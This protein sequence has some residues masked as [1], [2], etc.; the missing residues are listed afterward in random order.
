MLFD[1]S[2]A[3]A[4]LEGQLPPAAPLPAVLQTLGCRWWPFAYLQWCQAHLGDRFTVYPIDMPPLVFLADPEDIHTVLTASPSVLH[5]GEGAAVIAPLIGKSSFML[6]EED[7]HMYGR[8]ATIPAF[9]RAVVHE[10]RALVDGII[11]REVAS[12]PVD[13]PMELHPRLRELTLTVILQAIFGV[14]EGTLEDLHR[15]LMRMLGVTASFVLQE[16]RLRYL[17]GWRSTWRDF[18]RERAEVDKLILKRVARRRVLGATGGSLLDRLIAAHNPDGSEMSDRQVRDHLMS[19]ILAGHETTTAELA[20]AFQLLAHNPGVQER[21]T[22]ELDAGTGEPYLKA[23][24]QETLRHRPAFLFTIPRAVVEPIEI[25]GWTYRAPAHLLG[26]TYLMHHDPVLF[27]DPDCFRPERF[28]GKVR[29]SGSWLPWGT[30]HKRCIGRH[31]AL[32]EV[33]AVL[34]IVLS[35]RCVRPVGGRLEHAK[36]R[37]AILVPHAGARVR[38]SARRRPGSA[39]VGRSVGSPE[40]ALSAG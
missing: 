13:R 31:F 33:E 30:G 10:H 9:T 37:S 36:W 18:L 28:L 16:P 32:L 25:G 23:T 34:R 39:L 22:E 38:L 1:S 8:R 2:R 12:W 24:V 15:H 14:R 3:N 17:P 19:M 4:R 21:L 20:W 7:E 11:E 40:S 6:C 27:P 29:Q 26:C 5:P 35:S